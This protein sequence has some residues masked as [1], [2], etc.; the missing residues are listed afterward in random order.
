MDKWRN[1]LLDEKLARLIESE[2][3]TAA[4]MQRL[5]GG[6]VL[7]IVKSLERLCGAGRAEREM[8]EIATGGRRKAGG[9]R[10]HRIRYRLKASKPR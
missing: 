10:F 3:Q 9:I 7:E 4:Q 8:I 2:W 6:D 1:E 5:A